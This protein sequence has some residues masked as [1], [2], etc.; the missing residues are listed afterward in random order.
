MRT[1]AFL[2][3]ERTAASSTSRFAAGAPQTPGLGEVLWSRAVLACRTHGGNSLDCLRCS[4]APGQATTEYDCLA[5]TRTLP[6][7]P[8]AG[9][10]KTPVVACCL[11]SRSVG[12]AFGIQHCWPRVGVD[13]WCLTFELSGRRRQDAR[14]G[15]AKM[16]RVPP[17]RAWW[18]AVGAPL[19]RGVRHRVPADAPS[20]LSTVR[21]WPG[22]M[23]LEEG[24]RTDAHTCIL[25]AGAHRSK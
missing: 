21:A 16:Y 23:G 9:R 24:V 3:P 8:F 12:I 14:P 15:L 25:A 19:E 7:V 2:P 5:S 1:P 18:P 22:C 4:A 20:G 11:G 10:R 17:A 6:C 13:L